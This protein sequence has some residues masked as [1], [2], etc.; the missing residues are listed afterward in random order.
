MTEEEKKELD[1]KIAKLQEEKKTEEK[2][3]V[4]QQKEENLPV[5]QDFEQA[6]QQVVA[7]FKPTYDN[8]KTMY[9]NGKDLI[10][11]VGIRDAL[12]DE[13]FRQ[14]NKEKVKEN[15]RTDTKTEQIKSEV[16]QQKELYKK[17][18]PVLRF[19]KMKEPCDCKLMK[20]TYAWAIVPYCLYMFFS[21]V[22]NLIGGIFQSINDLFNS[23]FGVVTYLKDKDGKLVLDDKGKPVPNGAKINL[24][25][26]IL[27]G[28]IIGFIALL[29][30]S[31]I[32]TA[33]TGFNL[34][35]TIKHALGN[36]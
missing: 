35:E 23:I 8:K 15:I 22:F 4:V 7:N 27:F 34:I 36:I 13:D 29:L 28:V 19:A 30:V 1:A 26:K 10:K 18:E 31:G 16:E 9:E 21:C 5:S 33:L 17:Y 12:D 32:I 2:P 20:R 24:L 25:T 6:T 3:E 14:E 11:T